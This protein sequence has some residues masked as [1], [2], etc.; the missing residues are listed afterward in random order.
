[1]FTVLAAMTAGSVLAL[2]PAAQATTTSTSTTALTSSVNPSVV[3]ETV[4]L[5]ATVTGAAPTGSVTFEDSGATLDT[6]ELTDGVATLEV[7]SL[8]VGDHAL[9]ATYA[10]DGGN[11]GSV[12]ELTQTVEA[13][14]S[15]TALT[16]SVNPSTSGESVT[17]TAT[18]TGAGP[19]GSVTFADDG[20]P[21]DTVSLSSGVATLA[22]SSLSVGSHAL[23]ATYS[24]DSVNAGSVGGLTQ[25]VA[26]VTST[27]ALTSSANPST[28]GETITL[29]ATVTGDLPTGSVTF[30][31]SGVTL[32]TV[33]LTDGVASLDVSSLSVGSHAL[34]ATYSGDSVNAGSVGELTQTVG[35]V[36]S[37]TA[38]TSSANPSTSGQSVTLTATVTGALPTGSVT[39]ADG[40]SPLSTV[41]LSSGVATLTVSSLSVGSHALTATY[42]GDVVNAGSVGGL[43][44]TVGL[45]TSTTALTSSANPSTSGQSVTFT[46]TVTGALPT[47]SVTFADGG[48]PLSTVSLSSGAATL[49]V[50]SLSVG[51]H[52][53]TATYSGDSVNA[54][55]VGSM[56]QTVTAPVLPPPPPP[57]TPVVTVQPPKVKLVVSSE[58][59]SVGDK[60]RLR[61]RTKGADSVV[62]SGDWAGTQKPKGS[63]DIRITERGKHVFSLTVQNAAGAKTA[64]VKVL[65]ARK[66]KKL[67]LVVTS[68]LTM[69]G[70]S[71]DV[72]ADGL[73]K[74]EEY[75]IRLD[76]KPIMTGKA[77]KK[78]DVER[79]FT[80]AKT[81]AEGALALT[82]TG[83]NPSRAGSAILNVIRP[84]K[85]VVEVASPD[86]ALKRKQTITVTGLAPG[87][88]VTVMYA[89]TKLTVGKADGEGLF[90]YEFRVG[91]EAG[92]KTVKVVGADPS[93]S[94]TVTFNVF[95]PDDGGDGGGP[96]DTGGGG[97]GGDL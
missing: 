6:V 5:T 85:L 75:T 55:S 84:K 37:T 73:A 42:S 89:G 60:V 71:V 21:L 81:T 41:S 96:G 68:E 82:I 16:S 53:L 25:T 29:T 58:K 23:T 28:T 94:G 77:N 9:T 97:N 15:T 43:T 35:L 50:S 67:D 90:S 66:A 17:L 63:L 65:A 34:T 48:S 64:T 36:T 95:A 69:V 24:G 19:T 4:T 62:A 79:T 26:L 47:G 56:T 20:S 32:D 18:V 93:R 8:S 72:S 22:V 57:T 52:A 44:Q 87:E 39:F 7:S 76:D 70:S 11:D 80:V 12:G 74:G 1:M 13:V 92:K 14:T 51:S 86:V 78:G 46:A 83:S 88:T 61:W 27:T 59:V 31:D 45:V 91:K 54:G 30:E 40:G 3:G 38:L 33:D 10:G 2:A 49:S